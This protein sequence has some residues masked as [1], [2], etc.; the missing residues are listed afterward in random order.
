M[1]GYQIGI[2]RKGSKIGK[3]GEGGCIPQP[4]N[5]TD[6]RSSLGC[7]RSTGQTVEMY[8]G[9]VSVALVSQ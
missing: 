4:E 7:V 2:A 5:T 8:K 3:R 9:D 6:P 1:Q